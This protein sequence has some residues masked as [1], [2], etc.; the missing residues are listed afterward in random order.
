MPTQP[1]SNP[2]TKAATSIE[3]SVSVTRLPLPSS[4]VFHT[5]SLGNF[6]EA[7]LPEAQCPRRPLLGHSVNRGRLPLS[8]AFCLISHLALLNPLVALYNLP[9]ARAGNSTLCPRSGFKRR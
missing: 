3:A 4:S 8:A 7:H 5:P 1:M 2:T 9:I 6:R